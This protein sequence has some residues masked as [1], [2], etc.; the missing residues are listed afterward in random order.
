M[1]END[2]NCSPSIKYFFLLAVQ[3]WIVNADKIGSR[4]TLTKGAFLKMLILISELQNNCT[5][6]M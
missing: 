1:I 2:E 5:E 6:H 3:V 4:K